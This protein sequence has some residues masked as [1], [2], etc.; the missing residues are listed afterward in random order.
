MSYPR[1]ADSILIQSAQQLVL[2]QSARCNVKLVSQSTVSIMKKRL[3]RHVE[4]KAPNNNFSRC[5]ECDFLQDCISRYPRGCDEWTTLVNDRTKHINY[6]NACCRLYHGWSSNSVDSSTEFLC[7]IHDK[8]DHTKSAIPQMQQSTKAICGL[9]Q[10][11]ISVI[12]MLMHGHG[13]GAYAHYSTAFW[14]G[15]SNF[16]ISSICRVLRALER[17]PVKDLKELFIAPPQNSFFEALLHGKSKCSASIPPSSTNMVPLPIPDRPAVLLP[18][19]LFLQLDNSA[20]D[21]K[22][23]YVMAFY[24]LLT[25]KR[26][27]KEVTVGF[28]IV[29]HTHEDID[30]HFS[31]LSKLLKMKNTYVLANLMKAFMDSQK[32]TAFM[33]ELVQEVADFKKFFHGYQHDGANKL[34][35]LGEMHLFKFYVEEKGDN[36]GWPV[37]RY[38]VRSQILRISIC[39]FFEWKYMPLSSIALLHSGCR[40]ST[41]TSVS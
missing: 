35:G 17:P 12:G 31:Y 2:Q 33:P 11:P 28:L 38:K 24:P 29:G 20:K 19:K 36:M 25:A 4:V 14:P 27:F 37:M 5:S 15:D 7:I 30:A 16:T 26:L 34:I 40:R 3:F 23:R 6:Q 9:R 32:T 22:N 1:S 21:N 8:I 13:D 41:D 39:P 18:K 10:I